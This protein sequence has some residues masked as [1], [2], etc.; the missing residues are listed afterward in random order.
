MAAVATGSNLKNLGREKRTVAL[1]SV[2]A[3]SVM[4]ILKIVAGL[5]SGSLGMLSD[6]AHSGLDLLGAGLTF[7]SV[8]ISDRPADE[9]HTYGHAKVENISALAETFLM[10]AS[11]VWI[12]SEAIHRIFQH[13]KDIKPSIWPFAVLL[14]S[15]TVDLWRSHQLRSVAR[16]TGSSALEADALHFASDIWSSVA[17]FVGL[18]ATMLG[19]RYSIPLLRYADPVAAIVISLM[20]VR[21]SWNLARKSV[22]ELMDAVPA[23]TR[24]RMLAEVQRTNGVIGVEQARVRRSGNSYFAD[25]TLALPRSLTFQ[26]TEQLVEEATAA[27]NRVLPNA[28]VV[29]HTVPRE[30]FA[31]SIFD[32]V[33]AVAARNNV[34]IHDVSVQSFHGELRV[35]QH[36]EVAERMSLKDAHDF[37]CR[38][39][40]EIRRDIPALRTVL[41]HIES[42]PATI[43]EPVRLDRDDEILASNL[44]KA[45]AEFPEIVDIH[46]IVV[47]RTGERIQVSCHCTLPD[48]MSMERVHE[49][50]TSLETQFRAKYPEAYRVLIHPEPVTDN[51]HERREGEG[52]DR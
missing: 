25:L 23:D 37:V 12:V 32:R 26:R 52:Y 6:A 27:V 42:E 46:E 10:A 7:F 38:L 40:S 31:E 30:G 15:M 43:E 51:T 29:I 5:M 18:G 50:I 49:V 48:A 35:E 24:H 19:D 2:G 13:S 3:A 14:I 45:A 20:I 11:C 22:A 36:V 4:T 47:R 17:V 28:D 16:R 39:E 9:D 33:R 41:T 44:H 8:G 21:F 1:M 34:S